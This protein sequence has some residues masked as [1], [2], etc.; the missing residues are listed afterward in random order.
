VLH[1]DLGL[2]AQPLD[3]APHEPRAFFDL[4][5]LDPFIRLVRLFD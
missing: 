3:Q 5:T 4:A 2:S 1:S